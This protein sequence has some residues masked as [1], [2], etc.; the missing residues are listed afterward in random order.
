MVS[1]V[2]QTRAMFESHTGSSIADLIWDVVDEWM[3]GDKDPASV[4]DNTSNTTIIVAQ[5]VKLVHVKCFARSLNLAAQ[6]ALKLPTVSH[7]LGRIC[8]IVTFF[9]R[10]ST[11]ASHALNEK[12]KLLNLPEHK[13]MTDVA[14]R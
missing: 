2:L 8:S 5:L 10:K 9:F 14:T 3:L 6:R 11:I 4:T 13:L 7:L 1:H 12:Q